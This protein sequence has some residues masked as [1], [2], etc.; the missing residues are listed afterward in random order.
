MQG[1]ASRHFI[2]Q[3]SPYT[4]TN[5][6]YDQSVNSVLLAQ[7]AAEDLHVNRLLFR[8]VSLRRLQIN[9]IIMRHSIFLTFPLDKNAVRSKKKVLGE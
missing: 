9:I 6:K 3:S 4:K 2:F 8:G 5:K 7:A 1:L